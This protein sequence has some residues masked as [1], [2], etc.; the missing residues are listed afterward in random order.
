MGAAPD[1]RTARGVAPPRRLRQARRAK[2]YS[3]ARMNY[4]D[5]ARPSARSLAWLFVTALVLRWAYTVA[6]YLLFGDEALKGP[7]SG[8]YIALARGL[9]EAVGAGKVSGWA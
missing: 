3:V 2:P 1:F 5:I 8:G 7:D 6:F 4:T 9:A